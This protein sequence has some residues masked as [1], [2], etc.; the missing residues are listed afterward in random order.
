[1]ERLSAV[2]AAIRPD[3]VTVVRGWIRVD[4]A[5]ATTLQRRDDGPHRVVVDLKPP[6]MLAEIV[7]RVRR[8]AA[9]AEGR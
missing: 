8:A 6:V 3:L 2:L 5:G 4:S 9:T 7:T 1:M